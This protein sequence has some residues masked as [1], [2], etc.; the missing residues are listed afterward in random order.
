MREAIGDVRRSTRLLWVM[1]L[2]ALLFVLI[3]FTNYL[4]QPY[5]DSR[6]YG[7]VATGFVFAGVY[8]LAAFVAFR[9]R[10]I[11]DAV[12]EAV[13]TWSVL[14]GLAASFLLLDRVAGPWLLAGLA[15]QAVGKG[16]YSPLTKP[17]LNREIVAASRRATVLSIESIIRRAAMAL[18]SLLAGMFAAGSAIALCG[19][20]GL[21]GLLLLAVT[22][23]HSPALRAARGG[24]P[25]AVAV[26]SAAATSSAASIEE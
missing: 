11:R 23:R 7:L 9:G 22:A 8:L 2:S 17:M 14:G 6:G 15:L 21:V 4:Y 12:G 24:K 3:K 16:L 5:L 18:F 10:P 20:A 13:L 19:V 25:A 26:P 1:G